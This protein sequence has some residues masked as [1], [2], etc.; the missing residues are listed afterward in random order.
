MQLETRG[1]VIAAKVW[2]VRVGRCDLLLL[3]S[4]VEGN[5]PEDRELTARLYG[6][7]ARVRIRQELL[8]GV[9]GVRAL[10]AMGITP[11]VSAPERG[12]QRL[13]RAR[14]DPQPDERGRHRLRRAVSRVAREVVFTT[15]T[16]VP[17]G[18]DRF[19]AS[20]IEEHLGP[21]RDAARHLACTSSWRSAAR[22]RTTRTRTFCM[23]VLGLKLSRRAN[24]VSALHGEVS[25]AMWTGLYPGQGEEAVPI[26]HI[27][28]GVH[29]PTWLAPQ[30]SRLYDRHLGLEWRAA[31]RRGRRSGRA[32]K[33]VDD[34]ELWETHLSLKARLIDVRAPAGRG[35]GRR[36]ASESR[37]SDRSASARMLSPDALTIGFARRFATYKR[38]NLILRDLERLA[39]MVN[40]PQ[41]AG[42][43]RLRRQG[44]SARR[45][46]QARAAGDRADDARADLR[47]QVR[48]RRGLRHQR[49]PRS[50][51]RASTSG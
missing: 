28:N 42:A 26:G 47:R 23:T 7:D 30:M 9:G 31:E 34:G 10:R 17:A 40:D 43:V 39:A 50:W 5:S 13:R 35:A 22:T 11:S 1:G 6:G 41:A 27:T 25:R 51:C 16:P 37:G 19:H 24:A 32:S 29:V 8:L 38:A 36:A 15:H 12:A 2:R 18:H 45:A 21:L 49:R 3:D 14:S 20:L 46:G 4:N 48:V 33:S 44:A